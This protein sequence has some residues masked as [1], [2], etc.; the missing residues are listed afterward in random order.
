M[1]KTAERKKEETIKTLFITSEKTTEC[2]VVKWGENQE[3]RMLHGKEG[4]F[5]LTPG[6]RMRMNTIEDKITD[7]V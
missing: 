5:L 4:E 2:A 7:F 6:E 1:A 3:A